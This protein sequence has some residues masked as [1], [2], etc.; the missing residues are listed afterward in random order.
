[1]C[2]ILTEFCI[3]RKVI[4]LI[5]F[6]LNDTYSKVRVGKKLFDAFP[7][8]NGLEEGDALSPFLLNFR[9]CHQESPRK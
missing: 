6:C 4:R 1:L 3:P 8:H 2:N 7:I 5:K 9:M